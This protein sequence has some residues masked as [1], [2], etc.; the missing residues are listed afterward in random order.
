M[1]PRLSAWV[2]LLGVTFRTF[3]R[4]PSLS[5]FTRL[6]FRAVI[7]QMLLRCFPLFLSHSESTSISSYFIYLFGC[8]FGIPWSTILRFIM[9]SWPPFLILV[10][11]FLRVSSPRASS[12]HVHSGCQG[13][14]LGPVGFGDVPSH[15]S[16]R[17]LPFASHLLIAHL[18]IFFRRWTEYVA[19]L[20]CVFCWSD[21]Q[22]DQ[23]SLYWAWCQCF[24]SVT[25]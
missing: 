15:F 18:R 4:C 10:L 9:V 7:S 1:L 23:T 21:N 20:T 25:P 19:V 8:W 11:N 6:R 12:L 14:C 24:T 22:I 3:P 17:C 5:W 2:L 16:H 13:W